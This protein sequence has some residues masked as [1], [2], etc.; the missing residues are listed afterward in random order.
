MV[1]LLQVESFNTFLNPPEPTPAAILLPSSEKPMN[2]IRR[3]SGA[4]FFAPPRTT[5][6]PDTFGPDAAIEAM[7]GA[8]LDPETRRWLAA[9][10]SDPELVSLIADLRQ[11]KDNDDFILSE[12]G[13]LYLRPEGDEPALL[14]PPAGPIRNEI[15]NDAHDADDAHQGY[16]KM[17]E[18]LGG[19]FWWMS[20]PADVRAF[21]EGCEECQKRPKELKPGT[22]RFEL[23]CE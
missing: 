12:V 18:E 5:I 21:C 13:L 4:S 9:Y 2:H 11:G 10:P 7:P 17:M 20:M 6:R 22:I 3:S 15:I 19:V 8:D 1:N 14:V 23:I 16:E